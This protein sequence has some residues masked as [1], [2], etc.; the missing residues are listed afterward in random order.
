MAWANDSG[1]HRAKQFFIYGGKLWCQGGTSDG[2]RGLYERTGDATW[3]KRNPAGASDLE[4][5]FIWNGRIWGASINDLYYTTNGTSWTKDLDVSTVDAAYTIRSANAYGSY[6]YIVCGK[7]IGHLIQEAHFSRRT[8]GGS[9]S[10]DVHTSY[11]VGG[12]NSISSYDIIK[13]GTYTYWSTVIGGEG[14]LIKRVVGAGAWQDEPTVSSLGYSAFYTHSGAL[15]AVSYTQD[16]IWR[17]VGSWTEDLDPPGV[18]TTGAAELSGGSDGN[19]WIGVDKGS[20]AQLYTRSGGSWSTAVSALSESAG[21][22]GIKWDSV[23]WYMGGGDNIFR[24]GPTYTLSPI[25]AGS[26]LPPQSMD[27]DGDG[28]ILYL[29]IYDSSNNPIMVTADLPLVD[30]HVGTKA[31]DPGAGDSINVK[32]TEYTGE[33]VVISGYFGN[34]E[35]TELST[36]GGA[37]TTGIDPGSW[38]TSRAQ[39]IAIDPNDDN[40]VYLALD[41]ND[42]LVETDDVASWST[43]DAALPYDLSAIAVLDEDPNE[44]VIARTDAGAQ[45]I[46]HSP[47]QGTTWTDITGTLDVTAGIAN[48]EITT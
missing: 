44:I 36:D 26:D 4:R 17:Y 46:Q 3:T 2:D 35:Q 8:L 33:R 37:T 43:L 12:S 48:V 42:D 6:L 28:D 19:L 29:G 30:D 34:N 15:Y 7:L 13:F 45:L 25:G 41:G 11:T 5:V 24:N 10:H 32:A 27:V 38:G 47:N 23:T 18:L 20:T 14:T 31:F 39:P 9:W 16:E 22:G 21:C 1:P 40:H